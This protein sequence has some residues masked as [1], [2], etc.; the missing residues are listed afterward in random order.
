MREDQKRNVGESNLVLQGRQPSLANA[1]GS[2]QEHLHVRM[3]PT[4]SQFVK[5]RSKGHDGSDQNRN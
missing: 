3:L 4:T 2:A 1:R 5:E